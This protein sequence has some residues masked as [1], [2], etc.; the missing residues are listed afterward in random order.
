MSIREHCNRIRDALNQF[1]VYG[2]SESIVFRQ[3][4]RSGKQLVIHAEAKLINGSVLVI[5]EY[6]S[7]KYKLERL[8]YAYQYHSRD[9]ALIFRYDNAAH[10]P[11]L[12]FKDHKH[13]AGGNIIV[14]RPPDIEDLVEEAISFL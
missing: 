8:R 7:A 2:L 12:G 1:E 9:G 3:E 11:P 4:I 10:R 14:A 5:R 13:L 6:V